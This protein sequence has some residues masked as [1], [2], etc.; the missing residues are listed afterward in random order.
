MTAAPDIHLPIIFLPSSVPQHLSDGDLSL[1]QAQHEL[2]LRLKACASARNDGRRT[3]SPASP[4]TSPTPATSEAA[5]S[6]GEANAVLA[7]SGS[8][9]LAVAKGS[10]TGA[11]A[12]TVKGGA[13]GPASSD[14]AQDVVRLRTCGLYVADVAQACM[15]LQ[16]LLRLRGRSQ[17]VPFETR[18]RM[19]EDVPTP[20][21]NT[22]SGASPC[23]AFCSL[24]LSTAPA[25]PTPLLPWLSAASPGVGQPLRGLDWIGLAATPAPCLSSGDVRER[26]R[27]LS[28]TDRY[29]PVTAGAAREKPALVAPET[30]TSTAGSVCVIP[31]RVASSH[32]ACIDACLRT[33]GFAG[34]GH[35]AAERTAALEAVRA[36]LS[37]HPGHPGL[38]MLALTLTALTHGF[39]APLD[40]ARREA[41][42]TMMQAAPVARLTDASAS[43]RPRRWGGQEYQLC[44]ALLSVEPTWQG[45]EQLLQKGTGR[46]LLTCFKSLL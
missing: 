31:L 37:A 2:K 17:A 32:R 30:I 14:L 13:L 22:A 36:C 12:G 34:P 23:S 1:S 24:L 16:G 18:R 40:S 38:A 44:L 8:K 43:E 10:R 19:A 26:D 27:P 45:A 29:F 9:A 25:P 42:G 15:G 46:V 33:L 21:Y 41:L 6:K 20:D 35:S 7:D 3:V 5:K 28:R 39:G 4:A 11:A